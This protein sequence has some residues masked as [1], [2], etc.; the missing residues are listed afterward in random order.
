MQRRRTQ[1][2]EPR[3]T[4]MKRISVTVAAMCVTATA[5]GQDALDDLPA[6]LPP[7]GS[8]TDQKDPRASKPRVALLVSKP[9]EPD[10]LRNYG[11]ILHLSEEQRQ[12]ARD[13]YLAY[14]SRADPLN[15]TYHDQIATLSLEAADFEAHPYD[16]EWLR[17]MTELRETEAKYQRDLVEQDQAFLN[18][19]QVVLSD[20]QKE[21]LERVTL[22]RSRTR[23]QPFQINVTPGYIDL[24][25]L[26]EKHVK[27]PD[28]LG[29]LHPVLLE[30][31]RLITPLYLHID[32][33]KRRTGMAEIRG[34]VASQYSDDGKTRLE[35]GSPEANA[36]SAENY[37]KRLAMLG[38][39]IPQQERLAEI[40]Q[41]YV[42]KIKAIIPADMLAPLWAEYL[43]Q[44]FPYIH[45]DPCDPTRLM[46]DMLA[47]QGLD[48]DLRT[49]MQARFDA[50]RK[51][52]DAITH[53][54][55]EHYIAYNGI[56]ARTF[57]AEGVHTPAIRKLRFDRW[58]CSE[59]ALK[60]LKAML[61]GNVK[62]PFDRQVEYFQK[63]LTD[64]RVR[65]A[66]P[67]RGN[68]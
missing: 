23:C 53:E 38:E 12:A 9:I 24:V 2:K 64:E 5:F 40:N 16:W 56:L 28:V 55:E 8:I 15:E 67:G 57:T 32:E 37:K 59:E 6:P 68:P 60:S 33:G 13:A 21:R 54:M 46:Q 17:L 1:S 52:Y 47:V 4:M 63:R 39:T 42:E 45:P 31:E 44:S 19:L 48:A 50:W 3:F 58:A 29:D 25:S 61:P 41:Q 49:L 66:N 51:A 27:D 7:L 35:P 62:A 22:R 10:E 36:K 26:V 65:E 34:M 43:R 20:P 18:S 30:Y 11:L 14:R